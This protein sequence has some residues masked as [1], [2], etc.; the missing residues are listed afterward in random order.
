MAD[1]ANLKVGTNTANQGQLNANTK[2]DV[3]SILGTETLDIS[4]KLGG[5]S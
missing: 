5:E 4:L 2:I 1:I 3:A